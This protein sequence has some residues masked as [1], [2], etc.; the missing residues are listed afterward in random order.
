MLQVRAL[1]RETRE[2]PA[3]LAI[4]A[5]L[6]AVSLTDDQGR[7]RKFRANGKK[8]KVELGTAEVDTK[9][10]WAAR[11]L[12]QE[13]SASGLK[14]LVTY[15]VTVEGH[16]LVVAIGAQGGGQ[17]SSAPVTRIYDKVEQGDRQ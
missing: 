9:T 8:E 10:K 13:M 4:V 17:G 7:V 6:T 5:S 1:L 3:Q 12:T 11:A 2:A 16:Q 14:V 15:Q